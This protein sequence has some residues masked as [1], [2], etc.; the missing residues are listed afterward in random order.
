MA[1]VGFGLGAEQSNEALLGLGAGC[2]RSLGKQLLFEA[3]R[4]QGLAAPPRAGIAD[5]LVVLVV[6]GNAV[7]IGLDGEADSDKARRDAVAVTVKTEAEISVHQGQCRVSVVAVDSR[8]WLQRV[9]AE[10]LLR[11][12]AGFAVDAAVGYF[13]EPGSGLT[14]DIGQ[15]GKLAQ[16]P[17]VLTDIADATFFDFTFLPGSRDTA[18]ARV[19]VVLAG[20]GEKARIHPDDLA[21]VLGHGGH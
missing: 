19:E 2:G 10:S 1:Q 18:G 13:V 9:G 8:Q 6:E 7:R 5:D 15:I 4:T 14:I 20:K 11:A 21:I 16:G 12:L 3:F 17:E